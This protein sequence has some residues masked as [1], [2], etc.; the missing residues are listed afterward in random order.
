MFDLLTWGLSAEFLTC[1]RIIKLIIADYSSGYI[2][3]L[4]WAPNNGREFLNVCTLSTT[5]KLSGGSF[6]VLKG[7]I[8]LTTPI[9]ITKTRI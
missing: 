2:F 6:I 1:K 5:I 9:V 3:F 7:R 8:Y 4:P